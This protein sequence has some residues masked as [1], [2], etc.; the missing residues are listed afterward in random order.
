[1]LLLLLIQL[2]GTSHAI[3]VQNDAGY[4]GSL[5]GSQECKS[6]GYIFGLPHAPQGNSLNHGLDDFLGNGLHHIRL[7]DTRCYSVYPDPL[8][9]QFSCQ[10][11]RHTV[12]RKLG[13]RVCKPAG[14]TGNTDHGRGGKD[15]ALPS[16]CHILDRN[17]S[18]SE[19]TLY[20][21]IHDLVIGFLR[22][23]Q[24]RSAFRNTGIVDQNIY[25]PVFGDNSIQRFF[26]RLQAGQ[27]RVIPDTVASG[28]FSFIFATALSAEACVLAVKITVAPSERNFSTVAKPMPRLPPVITATLS[29]NFIAL[30]PCFLLSIAPFGPIGCDILQ[31]EENSLHRIHIHSIPRGKAVLYPR[32]Q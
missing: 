30:H 19:H 32:F 9:S 17:T 12:D 29:F 14:L 4:V 31:I 20:V 15:H 25:A 24:K 18:C 23:F 16:G 5:I 27:V 26:Y 7:R 3:H 2:S 22:V 11:D 28:C 8:W 13:C 6:V 1:M 10:R 21:Q